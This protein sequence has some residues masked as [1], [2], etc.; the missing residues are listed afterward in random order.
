M[1]KSV[2]SERLWRAAE[3]ARDFAR[4]L[5]IERLPD[6]IRFEVHLNQSHDGN[7]LHPDERVYP[8]DTERIPASRRSRL[9]REEA[10]ELL[11][12][13]GAVP[14]WVNLSV[15]REDGEHTL[16]GLECCG[17]F[18]ANTQ[19]LY[20]E[21]EG[22]PPFHVLGP[23]L[24][25]SYDSEK[26]GRFSLYWYS[27]VRSRAELA[28]L[29]ERSLHVET[30]VLSGPDL[31]DGALEELARA[32]LPALNHLG[33]ERTRIRG[34][35]FRHF[36][37]VPLRSLSW[38]VDPALTLDLR[39]LEPFS[40]LE[41]LE[42]EVQALPLEGVSALAAL[43][44]LKS[45]R[46]HAPAFADLGALSCLDS[47][48]ELDVTGSRVKSLEVLARFQRLDSLWL[49]GTAVEDE[50]LRALV[51]LRGLRVLGLEET[52]VSDAGLAH[53]RKLAALRTLNLD[54]T[55][56][57]DPGLKHVARL[58]LRAVR[59]RG[60]QVTEEGVAW[61]RSR[62][63]EL[64]IVSAFPQYASTRREKRELEAYARQL[65]ALRKRE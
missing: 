32:P 46:L 26:G 50:D 41:Q 18:T 33:L 27:E 52:A 17:R 29:R 58:R 64:H 37:D 51:G 57:G 56:V 35:G 62:C 25:P 16:I 23:S 36:V 61:L 21:R 30:L 22:Y 49:Q 59:L 11:W 53:L 40:R 39:S 6:A 8:E 43:P 42:V 3:C 20:H 7:P 63:P 4:T 1:D 34:P 45:F 2:F 13:E 12:R 10:V 44:G 65:E 48:E 24:S 55:R 60:T 47:L 38:K 15:S 14:E 5:V 28:R 19:R 54:K 9:T 31:D